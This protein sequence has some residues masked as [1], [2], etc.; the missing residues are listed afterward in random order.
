M[1]DCPK[2][3]TDLFHN[4]VMCLKDADRMAENVDHGQTAPKAV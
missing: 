4:P 1:Y 3:G 2:N